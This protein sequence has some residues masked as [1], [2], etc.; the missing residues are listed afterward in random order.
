MNRILVIGASGFVGRHVA[1]ALLAD[2]YVVRCLARN[3]SKVEDLA[4]AG[5]EIV[6]G[7]ISD[8]A[9]IQRAM[10]SVQAVYIS[11]HTLSPQHANTTGQGFMAVEM[12][13][14]GN[15][16]TTC[17]TH[18]VRRLIY[19]TFIGTAPDAPG[20][21]L[22]ERW[23][24]EQFLLHSGL[25]VTVI[26]P[27]Q[28][29][30]RGGRGFD[31]MVSQA[32]KSVAL[33]MGNGRQKWRNIALDDL[34]YYLLGVLNDPRA[35]G[36]AYDVGCDDILTNDQMMDVAAEILGRRPPRKVHIPLTLLGAFAPLIDRVSKLPKGSMKDVFDSLKGDAVGDPMSIRT[37]L[38][39]PLLSYRQ[40]V[41]RA[42]ISA[43]NLQ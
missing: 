25:D 40:A 43:R 10:A 3:P 1:L 20:G 27:T 32:R 26:R 17:Q 9:S 42:L 13:G 35:Y 34:I 11:I 8:L 7:D 4:K 23:K 29:V 14:L 2:G 38:P 18:G 30:A 22:R 28:I 31:I 12:N 37:I 5:C 6:Q 21:W 15:I 16:V 41:E 24:T 36:Q 39:R 33:I 19:V